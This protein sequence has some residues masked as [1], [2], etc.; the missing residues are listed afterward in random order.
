MKRQEKNLQA[1]LEDAVRALRGEQPEAEAI[2]AA[3][4]RVWQRLRQER[5]TG[6][7]TVNSIRG[8]DDVKTLLPQYR[9]GQL[10]PPRALFV[11]DH[12]HERADCRSEN[13]K[14]RSAVETPTP[15]QHALPRVTND[16]FRWVMAAA[17][18]LIVGVSAY[19]VQDKF[20][21]SP[22]GM[23]ASVESFSGMLYRV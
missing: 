2:Q 5:E 13:A 23:R 22:A 12:V 8:C 7:L 1:S 9:L 15:W 16:R 10:A 19:L 14:A 11:E 21:P 18:V 4:E 20:C 3:G 6:Q 17:A